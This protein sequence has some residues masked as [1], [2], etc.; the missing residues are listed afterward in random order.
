MQNN[1]AK[2]V[3][4]VVN[5]LVKNKKGGGG[6]WGQTGGEIEAGTKE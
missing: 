3:V 2:N 5:L 4:D 6:A 1:R